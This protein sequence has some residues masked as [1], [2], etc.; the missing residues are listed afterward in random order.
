[1]KLIISLAVSIGLLWGSYFIEVYGYSVEFCKAKWDGELLYVQI[2]DE[3]RPEEVEDL[4]GTPPS[5]GYVLVDV[6]YHGKTEKVTVLGG[7]ND[8]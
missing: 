5:E 4:K 1:M 2:G 6:D 7:F 8:R 3:L